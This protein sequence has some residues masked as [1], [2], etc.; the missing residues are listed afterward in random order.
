MCLRCEQFIPGTKINMVPVY[1][2]TLENCNWANNL[3][4]IPS[5]RITTA[6]WCNHVKLNYVKKTVVRCSGGHEEIAAQ[7]PR[8]M[9]LQ[10]V[11]CCRGP[12][13]KRTLTTAASSQDVGSSRGTWEHFDGRCR[14]TNRFMLLASLCS[15][16]RNLLF[17]TVTILRTDIGTTD[18]AKHVAMRAEHLHSVAGSL[19]SWNGTCA[20]ENGTCNKT[21]FTITLFMR[22][23]AVFQTGSN[24]YAHEPEHYFQTTLIMT[25]V[26]V[27]MLGIHRFVG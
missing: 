14:T 15:F 1:T 21:N 10:N 8:L 11:L 27:N 17:K 24:K 26:F 2:S 16:S 9:D 19:P 22:I 12:C 23:H 4:S 20:Q 18:T 6:S 25:F 3:Q 7:C 13:K 5:T